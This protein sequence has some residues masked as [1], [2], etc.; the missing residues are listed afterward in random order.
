MA[1]RLEG[2]GLRSDFYGVMETQVFYVAFGEVGFDTDGP[3]PIKGFGPEA[4]IND[5]DEVGKAHVYIN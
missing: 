1:R 2:G 4:T 5:D 3:K